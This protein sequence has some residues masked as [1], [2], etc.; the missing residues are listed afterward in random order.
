MS[1]STYFDFC[2]LGAG[3]AGISISKAL[4][5]QGASVCLID[6]GEIASGASGTPL[7]L[8]N[9]A[10]GR[11]GNK[12]W[13]A[14]KSLE[15]ITQDLIETQ[16]NTP[17]R[18]YDKTGILRPA[19]DEKMATKMK[20]N[21]VSQ[22]WPEG[23]CEWLDKSEIESINSDLNCVKGGMWLPHGLTVNVPVY[24]KTKADSLFNE[25]LRIVTN[26]DYSIQEKKSNY[27]LQFSGGNEI[28]TKALIFTA[29]YRTS[30]SSYWE[31][32]PLH[33][34]KGQV[35]IYES[36][37]AKEFNYSISALGYIASISSSRFVV[38]STYE[39]EFEHVEPDIEGLDYLVNRMSKVYPRLFKESDLVEQWAGVRAS[40]PNRKPFLGRHPEKENM[41]VFAGLGS[42]GLLYSS[43][44]SGLLADF[45]IKGEE[46]PR[47]ISIDRIWDE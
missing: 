15:S 46:I 41:Y 32:L 34:I 28:Q 21:V 35:A 23:W 6:V 1:H 45:I 4:I 43:Y 7:G 20:E 17:V 22:D 11:F 25:G 27:T 38:G 8:V 33:Q 16:E 3:L 5:D 10:T 36:S 18:F 40:A 31:F 42:K 47:I 26:A 9:P 2:V 19:Q 29:G 44:M 24:L 37:L 30:G 14:E 39:H 12:V 13:Q